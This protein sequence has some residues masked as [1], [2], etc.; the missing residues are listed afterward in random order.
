M[1]LQ[2]GTYRLKSGEKQSEMLPV[3]NSSVELPVTM[4]C[5]CE[6]GPVVLIS[7]GVHGAEYI[8]IQTAMELSREINPQMVKGSIVFLLVA[9][10]TACRDFVRFVVPEDGHNL[11][12]MFPGNKEGGLS[13]KIAYTMV[14][15]LQS[16][17]DYYIDIH[18]GDTSERVMPFVYFPGVAKDDVVEKSRGMAQAADLRVRVKSSA[19][20]GAY[21]NA[22]VRGIPSVLIERGGGG[23]FTRE[24]VDLYKQDVKKILIHLGVLEGEEV[25]HQIQ[26][27]IT[28]AAY[29]EAETDGF[30]YPVFAAGDCFEK[31]ALLGEITD[32]WGN[33]IE[34]YHAEY[35]G[36]VLYQTVGMGI[37]EGDPLIAYGKLHIY[38]N[39]CT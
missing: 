39:H 5:G 17:A 8:G 37:K 16:L 34:A 13:E 10:P 26:Q 35:D 36:I 27:E 19:T 6:E 4:I 2:V 31:G 11:N 25:H 1:E 24:E 14:H 7:A 3:I 32:V 18:A 22:G 12:R 23:F 30:W 9:N 28:R 38:R 20:T 15:E 29:L 33:Q 21:S